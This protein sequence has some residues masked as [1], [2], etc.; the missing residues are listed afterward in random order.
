M[1][2]NKIQRNEM[3]V[4]IM[5]KLLISMI[6]TVATGLAVAQP[7]FAD[8]DPVGSALIG[9]VAGAVIGHA[10]GG[11]NGAYVGAAL[12]GVSGAMIASNQRPYYE[13]SYSEQSNVYERPVQ[14][15]YYTEP[16]PVAYYPTTYYQQREV[17]YPVRQVT[18]YG[19]GDR[20]YGRGWHR[21]WREHDEGHHWHDHN[22]DYHWHDHDSQNRDEHDRG[23]YS[24]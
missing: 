21:E 2:T 10:V 14:T 23:N 18:Y 24:Y 4:W 9:G 16:A 8:Y 1:N 20:G 17:A 12:G 15:T 6:L 3:G 5:S 7:A 19:D 22:E 11:R 13:N